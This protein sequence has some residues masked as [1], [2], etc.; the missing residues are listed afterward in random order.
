[1]ILSELNYIS[2][3]KKYYEKALDLD[4]NRKETC[5]AYGDILLRFNQHSKALAYIRKGAGFIRFRQKDF[6][7]I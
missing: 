5:D 7:V 3:A 2:K 6:K 4:P 1:M